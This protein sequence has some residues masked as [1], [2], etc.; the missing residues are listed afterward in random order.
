MGLWTRVKR[1]MRALFGG[2]VERT[3]DPELILQQ[4]SGHGHGEIAGEK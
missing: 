4:T 2:I 1:S 3:E